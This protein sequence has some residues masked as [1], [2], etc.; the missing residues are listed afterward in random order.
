MTLMEAYIS[1]LIGVLLGG[2]VVPTILN[3][4]MNR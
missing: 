4:F 2:V 1:I 3:Y